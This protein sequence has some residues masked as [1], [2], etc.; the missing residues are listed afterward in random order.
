MRALSGRGVRASRPATA[1]ALGAAAGIALL[2]GSAAAQAFTFAPRVQP[3]VRIVGAVASRRSVAAGGGLNVP[4]GYYL[5]VGAALGAGRTTDER[6]ETVLRAELNARFLADPFRETR[7]GP[8][9]G[10][11]VAVD[12]PAHAAAHAAVT[13]L[14][15]TD[16]PGRG[17]WRPA[18][19]V[20]VGGGVRV[21]LILRRARRSGR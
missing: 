21:A 14:I 13:L 20:S 7:W 16:L 8:Y 4:A 1:R 3:E 5:R 11:G 6:A 17:G 10:V 9:A 19:E 12:W 2:S 18:A 15:G